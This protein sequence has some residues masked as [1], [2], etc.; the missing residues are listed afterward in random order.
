MKKTMLAMAVGAV[1][2]APTSASALEYTLFGQAK[3]EAGVI[4]DG[5]TNNA[6]HSFRGTRMG[7]RGS[8]DLGNGMKSIFRL[9]GNVGSDASNFSLNEELWAGIAGD[10]GQIRFGRH[11]HATKLAILPFRAFTDTIA[12]AQGF[13]TAR[14]GRAM[15]IHYRTNDIHGMQLFAT[16]SPNGDEMN[17]DMS[18]SATYKVGGIH[19][20]LAVDSIGENVGDDSATNISAGVNYKTGDLSVGLLY[21]DIEY[22]GDWVEGTKITVPVSYRMGDL[23]LRAAV[24]NWDYDD[25]NADSTTDLAAGV[26]Y[27]FDRRTDIFAN[28]WTR[29]DGD[30]TNFGIGMRRS[31]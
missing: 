15:G 2:I 31:F 21:Q 16:Y 24:V 1:I 13:N 8:S 14:W 26:L 11:D 19:A 4:D 20:A 3:Y 28:V 25:D 23:G 22:D 18:L 30:V 27:F 7:V 17:A 10:F 12:D 5:S 6:Q 29:N 9:Q